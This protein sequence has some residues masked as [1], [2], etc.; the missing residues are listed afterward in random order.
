MVL[1]A[2]ACL[3]MF[4]AADQLP[5]PAIGEAKHDAHFVLLL[6]RPPQHRRT[7]NVTDVK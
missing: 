3:W 4:A 1:V 7:E 2:L 5:T 6:L